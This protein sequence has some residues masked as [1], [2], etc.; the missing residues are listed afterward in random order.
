MTPV[1]ENGFNIEIGRSES[2]PS[3]RLGQSANVSEVFL[4]ADLTG[5]V[6]TAV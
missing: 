6:R 3:S 4:T 5:S 1:G 2:P